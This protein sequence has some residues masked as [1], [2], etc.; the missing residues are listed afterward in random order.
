MVRAAGI[1]IGFSGTHKARAIDDLVPGVQD[2][3]QDEA[4][5]GGEEA[6]GVPG[7]EVDEAVG[8]DDEDVEEQAVPREEGLPHGLVGQR[9]A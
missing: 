5:V 6:G 2:D 8:D 4:D 1:E 9:V 3:E 7:D